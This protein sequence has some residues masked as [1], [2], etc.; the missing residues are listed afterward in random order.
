MVSGPYS[1][2]K[3]VLKAMD[4]RFSSFCGTEYQ[5]THAILDC[6]F[7]VA[8]Y[9][10]PFHFIEVDRDV[11]NKIVDV[12]KKVPENF[13]IAGCANYDGYGLLEGTVLLSN[14]EDITGTLVHGK[15]IGLS[16]GY[17]LVMKDQS[18]PSTGVYKMYSK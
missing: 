11:I 7:N 14:N 12:K 2:D 13:S 15:T 1:H 16:K 6:I 3:D 8:E 9:K 17:Y 4:S 10:G 5:N 18:K